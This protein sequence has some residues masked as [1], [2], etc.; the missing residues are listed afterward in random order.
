MA[1]DLARLSVIFSADDQ[2]LLSGGLDRYLD[3][4]RTDTIQIYNYDGAGNDINPNLVN[5][6]GLVLWF[7]QKLN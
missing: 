1:A 7:R 2:I 3:R 5:T 6:R 4:D